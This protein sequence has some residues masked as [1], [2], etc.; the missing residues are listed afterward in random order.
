MKKVLFSGFCIIIFSFC[1]WLI[2]FD[3]VVAQCSIEACP[4]ITFCPGASAQ[5][6]ASG[7]VSPGSYTWSPSTGLNSTTI[8][9]PV[10]SPLVTTTYYV[11]GNG[12][13]GNVII[14]GDFSQGNTGFSCNYNYNSNLVPE[15]NY[16]VGTN[17][18]TFHGGFVNFYDH[19]SGSGN[20]MIV[21]GAGVPNTNVWCQT[22][23]VTPNTDYDFATWACNVSNSGSPALLQFSINGQPLGSIFSVNAVTCIWNQF[24]AIWNSGSNTTATICIVNQNTTLVGNDFALDDILFAPVCYGIDSVTV[25]VDQVN[26]S[27]SPANPAICPGH[28]VTLSASGASTY[29]WIPGNTPGSTVAGAQITVSP[30]TTTIYT[31]TGTDA[32][33]CTGSTSVTVNVGYPVISGVLSVCTNSSTQLAGTGQPAVSGAWVSSNTGVAS[34]NNSGMAIGVSAGTSIITYT[35]IAGCTATATLTVNTT[36]LV[37]ALSNVFV[38]DSGTV[39]ATNF[40]SN[41]PGGVFSWTNSNTTIGLG[42]GGTGNIPS[43]T[44][45]NNTSSPANVIITV[46]STLNNCTGPPSAYT[47]TVY[48]SPNVNAPVDID[49]CDGTLM[50]ASTFNGPL[51]GTTLSW[52]NSNTAV[53]LPAGGSGDV[54]QFNATNA[55]TT[56]VLATIVV[57]PTGNVCTTAPVTYHLTVNPIPSVTMPADTSVCH[58]AIVGASIYTGTVAGTTFTWTNSNASV[59]LAASGIGN[60]PSFTAINTG[61]IPVVANITVTP[62]ANNC[63]GIPSVYSIIVSPAPLITFSSLPQLCIS[64]PPLSLTHAIPAGGIYSG[65]G[66]TGNIFDPSVAGIGMHTISYTYTDTNSGCSNTGTTQIV[67]TDG[68]SISVSPENPFICEGNSIILHA[69]GAS[70]F[71]W[72]PVTGLSSSLGDQVIA[73]P[74]MTT[75]Y[76]VQGSNPDGCAGSATVAVGIYNVPVLAV[77]SFPKEGCSPLKV[78]FGYVPIGPIDTNTMY[79][80]FGD[81]SSSENS[82]VRAFPAHTF[83]NQGEYAVYLGAHTTEGCPVSCTDTVLAFPVPVADFYYNPPVASLYDPKINFIDLSADGT[84][85]LWDFGDPASFNSNSSNL[86]NPVHTFSDSGSFLVQ[87]IVYSDNSCSDTIEKPIRIYPEIIIFIPNAFTPNHDG[88]NETFRPII[89]GIDKEGYLFYIFDRWGKMEFNT[90]DPQ[91]GWDGK[92]S[93]RECEMGVYVYMVAYRSMTGKEFKERGIVNLIR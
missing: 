71:T 6:V 90:S 79:W 19:T 47:I 51:P 77:T 62:A 2:S 70:S 89:T 57:I 59:G 33:G 23:P 48:P 24:F 58:G 10:A 86:Q 74:A 30:V 56:P 21:N 78:N 39:A 43:F 61:N 1:L 38:C 67:V 75:V 28:S 18:H 32:I 37:V 9:N 50:L 34:V 14:N 73:S 7:G 25:F 40:T 11:T 72:Q 68:L 4:D 93:G 81:L 31:I 27:A 20:M 84:S 36:P 44:A 91:E 52:T 88:R 82:S 13:L 3:R 83:I 53:G 5:L 15:G 85:W 35:D 42:A 46:V 49:V 87:L 45:I 29:T 92:N 41:P 17:P 26:I 69:S 66:V 54:P 65:A 60:V 55:G 8:Y 80:N 12:T 64:S 22:V 63:T 16:Y 76:T